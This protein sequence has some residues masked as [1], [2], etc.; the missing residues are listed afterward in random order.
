MADL[1]TLSA[2]SSVVLTVTEGQS[3]ALNNAISGKARLEITTGPG[4]GRI[5]AENHHGRAVYG[6]FGAGTVTLAAISGACRYELSGDTSS[7]LDDDVSLTSSE[8]SAVRAGPSPSALAV[9]G[10]S[11]HA[12][13]N[14]YSGSVLW[15]IN[16]NSPFSALNAILGGTFDLVYDGSV[17]GSTSA[18]WVANQ[19]DG[20]ASSDTHTAWVSFP[21]NDIGTLTYA[22]SI[23]NLGAVFST[24][25][26]AGKTLIVSTAG[27]KAAW[28]G[29]QRANALLISEWI[30]A[31]AAANS[32]PVWDQLTA[33]YD[34][35]T[36]KGSTSLYLSESTVY[37][38][39]NAAGTLFTAAQSYANF[40]RFPAR[41][42]S[43]ANG[44][45]QAFY[46]TQL[47]GDSSG[48]P[49]G[50]AAYSSGTPT[51][52]SRA[53]VARTDGIGALVRCIATSDAA[54]SRYGI[55]TAS[56][57]LT[58]AWSTG[59]KAL[60]ARVKGS[61]GDHWVCTTAGTSSGTEP[62]AM[63][64]ASNIG[65]TVTD[66]GSVVWTRYK[67]ITPGTS[68]L[69]F[70]VEHD[71]HTVSGGDTG[72][73]LVILCA[74]TGSSTYTS[75]RANNQANSTDPEQ[76]WIFTKARRPVLQT[77]YQVL[78]PSGVT[79]MQLYLYQQWS[80]ASVTSSLDIYG[81]EARVD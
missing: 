81:V 18:D 73:Q 29:A 19:L 9:L 15:A 77:P 1:T 47:A 69:T 36:G 78:V 6:P 10:D 28:T 8:I 27:N 44:P 37:V 45:H 70:R 25:K 66:S 55:S 62:A 67:N 5:V 26:Q 74:F 22:Q 52:T 60:G 75:I 39:P 72:A 65:D 59:A 42:V 38:H 20:V 23:A 43:A 35:A 63:A 7:P 76:R 16:A 41:P 4:A 46:N 34:P 64:A 40:A 11:Y 58:A 49:D 53:K 3:L 56:I 33:T 79:A 54:G 68:K 13:P 12:A 31:Q 48:V 14:N 80:A 2:G 57:S 61:Y 30:T 50:W 21:T 71:V 32:W 17:S 24:L 51:T